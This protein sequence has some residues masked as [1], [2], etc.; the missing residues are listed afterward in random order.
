MSVVIFDGGLHE[1]DPAD[2]IVYCFD[3]DYYEPLGE[4]VE[5]A[6]VVHTIAGPDAILTTVTDSYDS[7]NRLTYVQLTGGTVGAKYSVSSKIT[8]NETTPQ[9]IERSFQVYVRQR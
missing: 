8:T 2:S 7:D 5:I 6:S 9:T 3:W 1:K 4:G